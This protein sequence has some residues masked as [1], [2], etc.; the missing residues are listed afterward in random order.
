MKLVS[1]GLTGALAVICAYGVFQPAMAATTVYTQPTSAQTTYQSGMPVQSNPNP[2][3]PY[4]G[5]MATPD[6][7]MHQYQANQ[8][9]YNNMYNNTMNNQGAT[10]GQTQTPVTVQYHY[11]GGTNDAHPLTAEEMPHRIFQNVPDPSLQ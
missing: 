10:P 4:G 5:Y 2:Y 9:A 1:I 7:M 6:Q 8:N 3:N 11:S